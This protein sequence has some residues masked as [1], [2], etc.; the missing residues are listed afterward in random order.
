MRQFER[1][2]IGKDPLIQ[3]I[4]AVRVSRCARLDVAKRTAARGGGGDGEIVPGN[5][6]ANSQLQEAGLPRNKAL[7]NRAAKLKAEIH[8]EAKAEK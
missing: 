5:G 3:L 7:P 6:G 4:E 8:L 2:K 1:V